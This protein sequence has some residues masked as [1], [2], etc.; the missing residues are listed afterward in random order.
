MRDFVK[1]FV[2]RDAVHVLPGDFLV[3]NAEGASA[4]MIV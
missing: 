2:E 3:P 1:F 4:F